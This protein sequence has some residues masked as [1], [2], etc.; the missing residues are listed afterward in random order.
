MTASEDERKQQT[1][2]ISSLFNKNFQ[3]LRSPISVTR[4]MLAN[5][6]YLI[7]LVEIIADIMFSYLKECQN[8]KIGATFCY[9]T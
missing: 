8:V 5:K 1:A 2:T 9:K 6:N 7:L 4:E 3:K